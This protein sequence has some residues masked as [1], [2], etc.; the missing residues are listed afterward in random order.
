MAPSRPHKT[1]S[2]LSEP[3]GT[4][5]RFKFTPEAFYRLGELGVLDDSRRYELIEGDI[6]AMPPIGPEHS[7]TVE[8][9]SR[10]LR[11]REQLPQYHARVQNPL[12]L[13]ASEL[14]PDLA[15]VVGAPEDYRQQHPTHALLVVEVANTTLEFDRTRKLP[16]YAG[17]GIP[18]CWILNLRERVLEVYR[19]PLGT[20]YRN[21]RVYTLDEAIAPLFAPAWTIPVRSLFEMGSE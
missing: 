12:R 4:V 3:Q 11:R 19:E 18:E 21:Q 5:E 20:R 15:I 8:V 2:R 10:V 7:V 13:G 6:Y 17:A 14:I 16:L 1:R 9:V